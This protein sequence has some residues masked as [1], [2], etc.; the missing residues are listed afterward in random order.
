VFAI[1]VAGHRYESYPVEQGVCLAGFSP[2]A[3]D[4]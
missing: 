1:P 2:R 3:G 4:P